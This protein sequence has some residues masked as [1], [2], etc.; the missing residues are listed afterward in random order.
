[1]I[2]KLGNKS[3]AR[4]TMEAANVPVI[5]DAVNVYTKQITGNELPGKWDIL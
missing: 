4:Q 1:M 3:I 5:P 2:Q